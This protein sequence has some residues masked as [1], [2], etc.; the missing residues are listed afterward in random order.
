M[1]EAIA[2]GNIGGCSCRDVL[3]YELVQQWV[4]AKIR[5]DLMFAWE[6]F[7]P[8]MPLLWDV[9][10]EM[11]RKPRAQMPSYR[12]GLTTLAQGREPRGA[13][14]C[15]PGMH[16]CPCLPHV[17]AQK[18]V[19]NIPWSWHGRGMAAMAWTFLS[20]HAITLTPGG[21]GKMS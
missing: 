16:F 5:T 3:S 19:Y 8:Q 18:F 1:K 20:C 15:R 10:V 2:Y 21:R 4:R 12:L 13:S 11:R 6:L 7:G 9:V 17:S 14:V